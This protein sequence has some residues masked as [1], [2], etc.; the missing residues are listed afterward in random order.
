[1]KIQLLLST[2]ILSV[3]A[4]SSAIADS[5]IDELLNAI[6]SGRLLVEQ[7]NREREQRFLEIE[8]E[9]SEL[10]S[11]AQRTQTSLENTSETL[12]GS[13]ER[14]EVLITEAQSRLD[15]RL[16][17]LSELFGVVQGATG[18]FSS[19]LE[20]SLTN[21]E[22]AGRQDFLRDLN[23]RMADST[24]LPELSELEKLWFE[25]SQELALL[26]EINQT[27]QTVSSAS[28]ER[29]EQQVTRV[30]AFNLVSDKGYL[31][32]LPETQSIIELSRQ[33]SAQ[34]VAY[35]QALAAENDGIV[36]FAFDPTGA[37]GGS[38]LAA[39]ID[40]PTL[41][42]RVHQGGVVG[43]T[44]LAIGA[45][46][47]LLCLE[48]FLSLSYLSMRVGWQLRNAAKPGKGNPLGR[49][50][51]AFKENSQ[52]DL[53]ALELKLQE[54]ILNEVPKFMRNLNFI[55]IISA[56]APLMGL[57][58]TVTGMIITF[59][60]ITLFGTGDP[61]TM[62]GGISSALI[63]TVLGLVVAIPTLL[64][65]SLLSS[66]AKRLVTI[67]EQQSA[68]LIAERAESGPTQ[69]DDGNA[70]TQYDTQED[71]QPAEA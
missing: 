56:V 30:G 10:L 20:F 9:R 15:Q 4:T 46:G 71:L 6:E 60:A 69:R 61:K 39:L 28:G 59:Q 14:N 25:M 27:T 31:Q 22:H 40:T 70:A 54:A 16:G 17:T 37:T 34:Y 64:L 57:L 7:D 44:I 49:V 5:S 45:L 53:E 52:Q 21:V 67:L 42:E 33:P 55:K 65:H 63:T 8:T 29:V 38:L 1:M 58:G 62:A 36:P 12:E 19:A 24:E 51:L 13:F 11:E 18:D 41:E 26:G 47:L 66:Q 23:A 48:R 32:Y 35:S 2:L 68:G 43:Y 3:T 50:L